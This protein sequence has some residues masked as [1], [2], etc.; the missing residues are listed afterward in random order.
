MEEANPLTLGNDMINF[1]RMRT[2]S[3]S[4]N[5]LLHWQYKKYVLAYSN[6]ETWFWR[7]NGMLY[8]V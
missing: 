7:E 2:L 3:H 4:I 1:G 5:D 6:F 8:S